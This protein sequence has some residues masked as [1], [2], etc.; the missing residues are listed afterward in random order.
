MAACQ[1][2]TRYVHAELRAVLPDR[3]GVGALGRALD[4]HHPPQPTYEPTEAGRELW[5]VMLALQRWGSRWTEHGTIGFE[6]S[7]VRA[8]V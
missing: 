8:Q 3:S 2:V 4:P 6:A 7:Q 1:G 5:G